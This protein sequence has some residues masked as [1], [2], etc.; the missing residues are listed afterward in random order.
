MARPKMTMKAA[1]MS[2]T[3]AITAGS[4]SCSRT[5]FVN[6]LGSIIAQAPSGQ[7]DEDVLERVCLQRERAHRDAQRAQRR[8]DAGDEVHGVESAN[9]ESVGDEARAEAFAQR[10]NGTE[11]SL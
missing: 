7:R 3:P 10:S 4:R 5:L 9:D 6:R 2:S 11:H 1:P 8:R